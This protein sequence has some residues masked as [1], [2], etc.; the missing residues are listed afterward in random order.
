MFLWRL[1]IQNHSKLSI[2]EQRRNKG[3]HLTW[4]FITFR[5][6]KQISMPNLVKSLGYIKCHSLSSP[7]PI[8][9]P[10]SF[11]YNC[12]KI[13]TWSGRPKTMLEIRKSKYITGNSCRDPLPC[14]NMALKL[15]QYFLP[16]DEEVFWS[17]LPSLISLLSSDTVQPENTYSCIVKWQVMSEKASEKA[18]RSEKAKD[19]HQH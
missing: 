10:N 7:R 13:C 14:T 3:K 16:A 1:S 6:V 19:M 12:E 8:K 11:R 9:S 18:I 2:T 17:L 15:P 4:N 5:F